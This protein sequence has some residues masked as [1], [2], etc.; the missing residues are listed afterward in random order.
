MQFAWVLDCRDPLRLAPFW[1]LVLDYRAGPFRPPY[2]A[3]SDPAGRCPEL[4]L[5]QV[6]EAKAGKNR[7]HL[8]VR[9]PAL[10][11]PLERLLGAGA[12]LLRG[13]FDDVGWLTA[14][15]ADPEGNEFCLLVPP[16]GPDRDATTDPDAPGS[17]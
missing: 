6:P 4:L 7:M 5:Q 13:P 10:D 9:V 8:D 1:A 14:V 17:R 2:L 15:L 16:P 12:R 11:G 3:L